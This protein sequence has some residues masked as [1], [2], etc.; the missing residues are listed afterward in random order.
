MRLEL[1]QN[2][3]RRKNITYS[4]TEI[5]GCGSIDF[6]HRGLPYHIWEYAD[7]DIPV[8]VETNLQH[9]G[10]SEDVEGDYE[11]TV[12]DWIHRFF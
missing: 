12:S 11:A 6:M 10:R 1:V 9:A 3:L 4:Y 7:T 5:D 2:A 8:G